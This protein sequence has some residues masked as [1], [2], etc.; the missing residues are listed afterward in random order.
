MK[1]SSGYKK[2]GN[3][4]RQEATQSNRK[5]QEATK[6]ATRAKKITT[7]GIKCGNKRQQKW[8]QRATA[9]NTSASRLS[10]SSD[11]QDCF[12]FL[13]L[14]PEPKGLARIFWLADCWYQHKN[15]KNNTSNKNNSIAN[16]PSSCWPKR[17]R[18]QKKKVYIFITLNCLA[19]QIRCV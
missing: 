16:L 18:K 14:C 9:S 13:R 1:K 5:Q 3:R 2:S 6:V 4:K 15:K 10:L 12:T 11:M 7:G 17:V 8:Q 19:Y